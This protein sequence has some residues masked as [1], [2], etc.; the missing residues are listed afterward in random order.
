MM[1]LPYP[2]RVD[3]LWAF[4]AYCDR[5]R[6]P[7]QMGKQR[8]LEGKAGDMWLSGR[9]GP[10]QPL[11]WALQIG[12]KITKSIEECFCFFQSQ[13]FCM[14]HKWCHKYLNGSK[15]WFKAFI[16]L[17]ACI[18]IAVQLSLGTQG[19]GLDAG[20]ASNFSFLIRHKHNFNND[21][22]TIPNHNDSTYHNPYV[23]P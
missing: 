17:E 10:T 20:S 15:P 22:K 2:V 5:Q 13:L 11:F 21:T 7:G 3:G 4:P 23:E 18:W 12:L 1:E 6:V 14:A 16:C 8:C 19:P 9:I